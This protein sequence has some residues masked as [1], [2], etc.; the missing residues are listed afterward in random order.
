MKANQSLL[1]IIVFSLLFGTRAFPL[2]AADEFEQPPI[3]Y[4]SSEPDNVVSRFQ[5]TLNR[6]ELSLDYDSKFGYLPALLKQWGVPVESQTLVFSKTSL[7]RSRISPRT[8]RALYFND[9]VYIGYCHL[10]DVLEISVADPALG[11]VFYTLDQDVEKPPL[12]VRQTD[13]CLQCHGASHTAHV[14]GHT[15]RSLFVDAGGMPL[16]SEGSHRVNQTTPIEKRWGGWYVTGTHGSQKHMGNLIVRNRLAEQPW[17]VEKDQNVTDL[18]DR[19]AVKNYL[20]PHSDL[21]AL[22]VLEHQ[23]FVHNLLVNANFTARQALHYEQTINKAFGDSLDRRLESTARRIAS[24]G[25]KLVQGLFFV[26]EA[27]LEGPYAGT[28]GYAEVFTSLGK[29][30]AQGRS[31]RDFDLRTRLFKYPCSYLVQTPEFEALPPLMKDYVSHRIQEVLQG[32]AGEDY[33]HLTAEDRQAITE[34]LQAT[35]NLLPRK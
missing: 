3:E 26:D 27:P 33:Q 21:I 13:Q 14:P 35:T 28:S 7:Q 12:F 25:E 6:G 15:V 31:L 32:T 30:D 29:R 9:S 34:I 10:G 19:L 22:L 18:T 4:S 11:T 8:P 23:T 20:S 5:A 1:S 24:A 16:L 2:Q 17:I